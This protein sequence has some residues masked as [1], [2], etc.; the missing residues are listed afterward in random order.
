[1]DTTVTNQNDAAQVEPIVSC[2]RAAGEMFGILRTELGF[3]DLIM[4]TPT[5][6][7]SVP[8]A[9]ISFDW[10]FTAKGNR[11]ACSETVSFDELAMSNRL[12]VLAKEISDRWKAQH[13]RHS[14]SGDGV[15]GYRGVDAMTATG[16]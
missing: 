7:P 15:S 13:R 2:F 14:D 12:T 11:Y 9:A 6:G 4:R 5:W 16:R 3:G 8:P 10:S 1:M